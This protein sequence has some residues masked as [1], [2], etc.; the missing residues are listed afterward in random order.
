ML[1][2]AR[3]LVQNPD[4]ILMDEPSEGLSPRLVGEVEQIIRRLNAE[5]CS[6]L[7]VEQNLAFA[8]RLAS[9]VCILNK[10]AVVYEGNADAVMRDPT[11][12]QYLGVDSSSANRNQEIAA[13]SGG[14]R[15]YHV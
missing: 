2:I 6:I 8:A 11:A 7:L 12:R 13:M 14:E 15:N 5:G 9:R 3:A 1:A 10:G 4:L